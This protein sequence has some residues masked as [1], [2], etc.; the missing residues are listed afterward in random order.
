MLRRS[1][2]ADRMSNWGEEEKQSGLFACWLAGYCTSALFARRTARN[3]QLAP[4]RVCCLWVVRAVTSTTPPPPPPPQQQW[5]FLSFPNYSSGQRSTMC[6]NMKTERMLT[7][8]QDRNRSCPPSGSR[9]REEEKHIN[10]ACCWYWTPFPAELLSVIWIIW[11]F[12]CSDRINNLQQLCRVSF[13]LL[14][15]WQTLCDSCVCS[16]ARWFNMEA[17][18]VAQNLICHFAVPPRWLACFSATIL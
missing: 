14:R 12:V 5:T 3:L 6:W 2:P 13:G 10:L 1:E 11:A 4:H 8:C 15:L 17:R 16:V 7:N 9:W 18:H